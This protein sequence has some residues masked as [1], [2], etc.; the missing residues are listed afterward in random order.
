MARKIFSNPFVFFTVTAIFFF[1]PISF[2]LFSFKNDT[3][4]YYYPIRTLISD[5]LNNGELPL[6][7]P[8]LNM[9]YPIH[10]DL[11]S[12]AWNPIIWIF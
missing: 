5:A 2:H 8:F 4:T 9:G 10:A 11:Q 6:W 7:T 1:W 3:I 12:G